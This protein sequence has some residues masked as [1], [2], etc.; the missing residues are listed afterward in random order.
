MTFADGLCQEKSKPTRFVIRLTLGVPNPVASMPSDCTF[1]SI[2]ARAR[3]GDDEAART[4]FERYAQRLLALARSRLDSRTLQKLDPEDVIQSVFRSFFHR[5]ANDEYD[6]PNWDRLWSLLTVI[7]LR[8][9]GFRIRHFRAACRNVAREATG[10]QSSDSHISWHLI[11]RE[12]TPEEAASLTETLEHLLR[13]LD[14]RDRQ[15]VELHLRGFNHEQ[16]SDEVGRS[17]R[18]VYRLL[19]RVRLRLERMCDG[20]ADVES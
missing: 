19:E 18:S 11:A 3:K 12:P 7:T 10:S 13:D 17:E 16:I 2:I 1:E 6:V 14:A 8:K 4:I 20:H 15:I 5:L 9:C